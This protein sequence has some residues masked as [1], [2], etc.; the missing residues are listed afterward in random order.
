ME[1]GL[2]SPV[3]Q[4]IV[5]YKASHPGAS[6]HEVAEHIRS[7]VPGATT[8]AASV[9][10]VLSRL[11]NGHGTLSQ[12]SAAGK[13]GLGFVAPLQPPPDAPEETDEEAA[14]RITVRY[15]AYR[16]HTRKVVL[17]DSV[18]ALIC[19][20]PPGLGKSYEVRRALEESGRTNFVDIEDRLQFGADPDGY[21]EAWGMP[22]VYD[23][24]SGSITAVGLYQA[25]WYMRKG[26]ILVLDD[27]DAVFHDPDALNLLK[28]ALDTEIE[29]RRISWRKEA[30]WLEEYGIS[31][32]F[33]F[34]GSVIFLTN[35]DFE[36]VIQQGRKDAEHFK[37]LI[38]RSN[39]LCLTLRGDRDFMIRIRQVAAGPDGMIA[40][41]FG[42]EPEH[43]DRVLGWISDNRH[44]FYNLSLRLVGQVCEFYKDAMFIEH[45][46]LDKELDEEVWVHERELSQKE[47]ALSLESREGVDDAAW[48]EDAVATKTRTYS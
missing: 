37:A 46:V 22:G 25:L 41:Q 23:S 8:S 19:S 13:A 3:T 7:A 42:L 32:S 5:D 40:R 36:G 10:S 45:K 48:Q 18:S 15:A 12:A 21:R 2:A 4:A 6:N 11:K 38:D 34:E 27:A 30:R 29:H 26:G 20:G 28:A 33:L 39:Y 14:T 31:R 1:D 47:R 16:R 44:R 17:H 9:S 35:I 24:I 43:G